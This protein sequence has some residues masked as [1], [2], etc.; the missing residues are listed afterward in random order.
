MFHDYTIILISSIT[1]C[2]SSGDIY[3]S[4]GIPL[5]FLFVTVSE[6]FCCEYFETFNILLAILLPIKS[7]VA[8]AVFGITLFEALLNASV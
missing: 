1:S 7:T 3:L 4:L 6:L 2:L 8:S 5:S